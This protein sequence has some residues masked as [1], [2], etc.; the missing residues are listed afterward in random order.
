M[1]TPTLAFKVRSFCL[2]AIFSLL[3]APS[4]ISTLWHTL[5]RWIYQQ[6]LH[7]RP[8]SHHISP[9]QFKSLIPCERYPNFSV[10][11]STQLFVTIAHQLSQTCLFIALGTRVVPAGGLSQSLKNNS[12]IVS[13]FHSIEIGSCYIATAVLGSPSFAS[14][15]PELG[16]IVLHYLTID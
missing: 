14:A 15:F 5:K 12:S 6:S 16:L 3:V 9:S 1:K 4:S 8:H 7:F 11:P 10:L 13:S 2:G